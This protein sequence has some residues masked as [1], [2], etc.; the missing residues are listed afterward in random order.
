MSVVGVSFSIATA[1]E[2]R[3]DSVVEVTSN[4]RSVVNGKCVE[5]GLRDPR[6]GPLDGKSVCVTCNQKKCSGHFGHI[7]LCV[8]VYHISWVRCILQWLRCICLNCGYVLIRDVDGAK[9]LPRLKQLTYL[10]SHA[11]NKCTQCKTKV[12]KFS[13]VKEEQRIYRDAL[14]YRIDDV[15]FHL[16]LIPDYYIDELN[17]SH[18]RS[19]ILTALPVPP[20]SV[21]QPP[22]VGGQLLG[23]DDLTYR[24]IQISRQNVSLKA[25]IETNRPQFVV[26]EGALLL[27]NA[28]TGYIDHKKCPGSSKGNDTSMQYTSLCDNFRS[29]TGRIR[30]NLTGKRVNYTARNVITGD[31]IPLD[32]IGIPSSIAKVLTKPIKVTSWNKK[33]LRELLASPNS[34]VKYVTRPNGSKVDLSFVN[35]Q[36]ITLE[37]GWVVERELQ[38]GDYV[39][40][41]RQ[42]TLHKHSI[43][44]FKI[45]IM[46]GGTFRMNL[47]VT[48]PFNADFDGDEMNLHVPQDPQSQAE[49]AHVMN[50]SMNIVSSQSNRPVMS[51]IQDTL[52]G[53]FLLTAPGVSLSFMN[54]NR[55]VM[56]IP[57]WDGTMLDRKAEYTGHELVSMTLPIVNWEGAGC[58]IIG[59]ELLYGQLTKSVL[60][61]NHQ[62]L[63][64]VIHNDCG[65]REA[66][67]FMHRLQMVV[68]EYLLI[69]GFSMSISDIINGEDVLVREECLKAYEAVKNLTNELAINGHLNATRDTVGV[70]VQKPLNQNNQL[71]CMVKSG[72]KGSTTN[73]SQIKGC[74][75]QQNS[76]GHRMPNAWTDRTLTHF[77]RGNV[78]PAAKGFIDRNYA[79]GLLPHQQWFAAISG[80]EGVIDTACKT[81]KSGYTGRKLMKALE[82]LITRWDGTV[83]NGDGSVVQFSYGDDG[84][85]ATKIEKQ[86]IEGL[87][88]FAPDSLSS[89]EYVQLQEDADYLQKINNIR[90]P[91]HANTEFWMLPVPVDRIVQNAQTIFNVTI[92]D[93][94]GE[95]E[96]RTTVSGIVERV[97]N[98]LL[99]ILLRNRLNTYRLYHVL[100]ITEDQME[101]ISHDIKS[102]CDA[103]R[104]GA[105]EAV[106]AV[107]AQSIGEK[108]TQMTL[109]TF[110]NAGNSS[111]NVTLGIPR[112]QE[113]INCTENLSAPC[114]TFEHKYPSRLS[115]DLK[116]V[117]F[118][119]IVVAY[120][121]TSKPDHTEVETF[122]KFPD[123]D[124]KKPKRGVEVLVLY[125][126]KWY[127]VASVKRVLTKSGLTCAYTE[128]PNPVFHVHGK[129]NIET[130][131]E[132]TLRKQTIRGVKGASFVDVSVE[133]DRYTVSTSLSNI[134]SLWDMGIAMNSIH[135]NDVLSVAKTLG[136]EA[137]RYTLIVE[138]RKILGFYG[139]Y[140]NARHVMLLADW[141][142]HTGNMTPTTRHGM[143]NVVESPLQRCTFE[144]VV[145]VFNNAAAFKEDD[146]LEGIS[147]RIVVGAPANVGTNCCIGTVEDEE[148][149]RKYAQAKPEEVLSVRETWQQVENPWN[150]ESNPWQ[151]TPWGQTTPGQSTPG[152][153]HNVLPAGVPLTFAPQVSLPFGNPYNQFTQVPMFVP[154]APSHDI[155]DDLGYDATSPMYDP[156]NPDGYRSQSPAYDPETYRS[157]SPAYDPET[158]RSESPAYDPQNPDAYRPLSPEADLGYANCPNSYD[159]TFHH[160]MVDTF[161]RSDQSCLTPPDELQS[162][163]SKKR[164]TFFEQPIEAQ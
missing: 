25:M 59:G 55:C 87:S 43:M 163:R 82:N 40:F 6:F 12:S 85:D 97:E 102:M 118:F 164:R 99:K 86:K 32:T 71:F 56:A 108:A 92:S 77:K 114:T 150:V 156:D 132:Q 134:H 70:A 145:D 88:K 149:T 21:R 66:A 20:P 105:G 11:H 120:E 95:D 110:H 62:S 142:T 126:K 15:V 13:W 113:L 157:Q 17:M 151:T 81:A 141:M 124:Y 58:K 128:G 61:S 116:H 3:Q 9:H 35:R 34:I 100:Q 2:I 90:D 139:I 49:A 60:G 154:T 4:R 96:I 16:D 73:I 29:K 5:G 122:H 75:G 83:C 129:K 161:P 140:L 36:S 136:V 111:K 64:H 109:N 162:P 148:I 31:N 69:R 152:S 44:G 63:I 93:R 146:Y 30:G 104:V 18:P 160:D 14:P 125:M 46:G 106:G 123:K 127:D 143:K 53:A 147:Q 153:F 137:G 68:T 10:S 37:E 79:E 94:L 42:P 119:D 19:M 48:P 84:F 103:L 27:Q 158:Y 23:E 52:L 131:Y 54:F 33:T 112:L 22:R 138:L 144:E 98:E 155:P 101:K 38:N 47:S 72:S 45:L 89:E 7:E 41:N 39:L 50:A 115:H 80:R 67:R 133:D 107:A 74:V 65:S 130:F 26:R 121:S 91:I 57:D 135:T 51:I 76:E 78:T 28:V 1:A 24:L 117:T 159:P 8:P